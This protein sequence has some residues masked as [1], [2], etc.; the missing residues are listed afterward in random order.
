MGQKSEPIRVPDPKRSKSRRSAF[1]R[2]VVSL[3]AIALVV[4]LVGSAL[5]FYAYIEFTSQGPLKASKIHVIQQGVK[6]AEI[7]AELED[8]GIVSS[9]GVFT[10]AAYMNGFLG[11]HLKAGEYEFPESASIDEVLSIITSGRAVT[12][13]VTVPEGWTSEMAAARVAENDVLTGEV[14]K[15]PAEGA[16]MPDTYVFHR[17]L[18]R[19]KMLEDMQSAQNKLLDE[20]WNARA[21]S[22]ILKSKEEAVTLASIVEKETGVPEERPLVASV[23]VNRLNQ[24]IRLQS[25]PTIIYGLVGGKGKLDRGITR[26][27]L[28][29]NTPYNTYQ[30]DGL[31]PG[32]IANPGRASLEAVLNPPD[33]GY[34]YFVANGTGGHAFAKTLEEHNA[35]VK[36]W[37]AMENG[38]VALQTTEAPTEVVVDGMPVPAT[39][40][41][42]P[43]AAAPAAEPVT[44]VEPAQPVEVAK[45]VEPAKPPAEAEK[46]AEVAAVAEAPVV[47]EK[48]L[49]PGTWIMVENQMVP[50][51]KQKPKQ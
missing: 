6:R 28:A 33:T 48:P 5:T 13:K 26:D 3:F 49:K 46:P 23:F 47:E 34:V 31:P 35:N 27:D 32:P 38:Q 51:P 36:K 24:G 25:D 8:A 41:A 21:P 11:G 17:G 22:S 10:A 44:P 50:I 30:I 20:L 39:P 9:A 12:Y 4:G 7:G 14:T 43:E 2:V 19:Q 29:S 42:A 18:T 37:R 1:S 45:P 16:I 15:V 40:P